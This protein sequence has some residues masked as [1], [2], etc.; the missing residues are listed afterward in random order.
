MSTTKLAI[1]QYLEESGYT[2][3]KIQ[4]SGEFFKVA[5]W[6]IVTFEQAGKI[7]T[8][9]QEICGKIPDPKFSWLERLD[10]HCGNVRFA[11]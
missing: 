7:K 6:D 5:L 9:L 1:S 3:Y 4:K 8:E 2:N 10:L 11:K